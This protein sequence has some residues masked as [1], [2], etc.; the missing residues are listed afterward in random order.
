MRSLLILLTLLLAAPA[1]AVTFLSS[2]Q[3]GDRIGFQPACPTNTL[4]VP[5]LG[6][7]SFSVYGSADQHWDA[8][9]T[10][11]GTYT[12]TTSAPTSESIKT[13]ANYLVYRVA[14]VSP[15]DQ[16]ISATCAQRGSTASGFLSELE[17]DSDTVG[18]WKFNGDLVSDPVLTTPVTVAAGAA[19]YVRARGLTGIVCNDADT[20]GDRMAS[21]DSDLMLLGDMTS[22]A[23]IQSNLTYLGTRQHIF[24]WDEGAGDGGAPADNHAYSL[25][26]ET[27]DGA[28]RYFSE[29]D[30]T[31]HSLVSTVGG[32][33]FGQIF[34][35]SMTRASNVVNLYVDGVLVAGPTTLADT[36]QSGATATFGF[37]ANGESTPT[38]FFDGIIWGLK[39]KDVA[40]SAT[41]VQDTARAVGVLE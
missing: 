32:P 23:L 40:E 9:D 35:L 6:T 36:P 31:N 37:C 27:P 16:R 1:G 2:Y 11:L 24:G 8:D 19:T 7:G 15:S 10:L 34:L 20:T 30:G 22:H 17:T 33:A 4:T 21:A 28:Y 26:L 5:Q 18:N 38:E 25:T 39:I 14:V 41:E 13:S 3:V 29:G 12:N